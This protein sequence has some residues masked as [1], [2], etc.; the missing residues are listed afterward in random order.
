MHSNACE[1]KILPLD[2]H[3]IENL[4]PL[5]YIDQF[6]NWVNGDANDIKK[7]VHLIS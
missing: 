1:Y 4:I 5:N 7:N 3:E 6:D 2:V